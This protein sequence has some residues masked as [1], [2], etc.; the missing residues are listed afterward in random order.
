[1]KKGKAIILSSL[2]FSMVI[3]S[4]V[5]TVESVM[6]DSVEIKTELYSTLH[7]NQNVSRKLELKQSENLMSYRMSVLDNKFGPSSN[8]STGIYKR[9]G[10]T[11]EIYVDETTDQTALP[12]YS[13]SGTA[14][15][16]N[17]EGWNQIGQLRRGRNVIATNQ[18]GVIHLR[19]ET[20]RT[21]QGKLSVEIRGGVTIPR[22]ILG[23]TTTQEWASIL[24][25][26]PDAQGY[27]LVADRLILT[28][29]NRTINLVKDPELI[30]RSHLKVIE[31]H[32][33][34]SG[35]DGNGPQHRLPINLGQHMRETAQD[36]WYMYAFFQHTGY[37]QQ[38]GMQVVLD[39]LNANQ[40]GIWHELG[41]IYQM[42]RM[43]WRGL[44]EV[45]VNIFSLR[46]QKAL[47]VRS[48]LEQE[49]TY[50]T[51]F[52]YLN[53]S[54]QKH[55][56]NQGIWTRLGMF[57]QLELAFGEDFYPNLHKLYREEA[58]SLP[59]EQAK[60]QYFV[61]SASKI[62]G[63]NL[64]PF[65]EAWGIE[66]TPESR[67]ELEKLPNLTKKIWEYRDEMTGEVGNIDGEE[68]KD[69]Q[70]P[71]VPTGLTASEVTTNSATI[72][73]NQA[74]DNIKV[75]GYHIYRDGKKVT[76][77]EGTEFTDQ[78]LAS[79]T[80]YSYEVSAYDEAGNES[81]KSNAMTLRT[82]GE[83]TDTQAP[84]VP[85]GLVAE[86]VTTNS[87]KL[88][89]NQAT[90]DVGVKGYHIYRNTVRVATVDRLEHL[91]LQLVSNTAYAY[92][93]S[94][95][96]EAGNE[97]GRSQFLTV[98][99][100][101]EEQADT[102]APTVPSSL[103]A[104]TITTNSIQLNWQTATDNVAVTGYHIY[105]DGVRIQSISG[106]SFTDQS[107]TSNTTY[108]YQV[109][110]YDA[111]GNESGKSQPLAV[112]TNEEAA[113]QDTWRSDQIYVAGD[114]VIYQGIEYRAKWWV[115]GDRPDTSAAWERT[116]PLSMVEWNSSR[117][118]VG[119]ERV[120]YQG[121]IY[122]ARWWN[123]NANPSTNSV[124]VLIG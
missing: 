55:F 81:A 69:T 118:Y 12:I 72:R 109:S 27:E 76:S 25:N 39:P 119:G 90:D 93:V 123:V 121:K 113:S 108:T 34:T 43:D 111:A 122:E 60:R 112:K 41:H 107:L 74:S 5:N 56:D 120:R 103:T 30:L 82:K 79:D 17:F 9:A 42:T 38:G 88:K 77:V 85:N 110:A 75:K 11:I 14:L 100:R 1:M 52:N 19:N 23:E 98:V 68:N 6:D 31:L 73:W 46:A 47:G 35:L 10:D 70:A 61:T 21:A 92:Q 117:S 4:D 106:T 96:D 2:L 86:E 105:R 102:Q 7:K 91:D 22:F 28:G 94:A 3:L 8:Q 54:G 66:V 99:T 78:N 24:A 67:A 89:W 48:R 84:S 114:T 49:N 50:S 15:K 36:S 33:Q 32:D 80:A 64:L 58:R 45:T 37:H 29:S 13:I 20:A 104:G 44:D 65:F 101:R 40:W 51:I 62:S 18:E 83:S 26:H 87:V 95:F 16:D 53:S 115:R 97:S 59:S 57:W 71:T 116:S 124:W 63:K